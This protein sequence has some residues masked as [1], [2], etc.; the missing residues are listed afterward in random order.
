MKGMEM[1]HRKLESGKPFGMMRGSTLLEVLVSVLIFSCGMLAIAA[2]QAGSVKNSSDVQYRAEAIQL[3]NAFVGKMKAATPSCVPPS[4]ASGGVASI[5]GVFQSGDE[6]NAFTQQLA[7]RLPGAGTP[8]VD[9]SV[10]PTLPVGTMVVDITVNWQP[11]GEKDSSGAQVTSQY[12]Q[13]SV[14]GMN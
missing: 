11:P 3:V 13:S 5:Q 7:G 6:F 8:T 12:R 9:F 10:D 4:C 14:I 2:Q 1:G